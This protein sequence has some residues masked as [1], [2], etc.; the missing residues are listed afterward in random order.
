MEGIV[1]NFKQRIN[2]ELLEY[3]YLSG[4]TQSAINSKYNKVN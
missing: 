3:K 4:V 2:I 1:D